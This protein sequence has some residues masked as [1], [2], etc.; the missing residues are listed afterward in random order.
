MP[1]PSPS[2]AASAHGLRPPPPSLLLVFQCTA[3][4]HLPSTLSIHFDA[5]HTHTSTCY[6]SSSPVSPSRKCTCCK[7][8]CATAPQLTS[9]SARGRSPGQVESTTF[10]HLQRGLLWGWGV[11]GG[12][13]SPTLT[14]ASGMATQ[15]HPT[16][17]PVLH[18]C[19]GSPPSG[20]GA[21]RRR[22]NA[23]QLASHRPRQWRNPEAL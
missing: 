23:S 21:S 2:S 1:S 6:P 4:A 14:V 13:S 8:V 19:S 22:H 11:R 15:A 12:A 9:L 17:P 3:H 7:I 16:P 5:T 18:L 20:G 10:R